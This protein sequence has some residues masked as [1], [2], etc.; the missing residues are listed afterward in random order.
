MSSPSPNSSSNSSPKSSLNSSRVGRLRIAATR[1]V[2]GS[3][4]VLFRIV[5]GL[6]MTWEILRY[7][8][9]GWVAKYYIAP[10]FHFKYWPF[11]FVQAWPGQGMYWH[12]AI[13]G[14]AAL[15]MA[16]GVRYRLAAITFFLGIGWIF[17]LDQTRYL[18]HIYL[19]VLLAFLMIFM[20]VDRLASLD[21]WR[22][23][24]GDGTIPAWSLWLMRFQLGVPYFFGGVA[25][26]NGDWLRG[27]PLT[28][29]LANKTHFPL[30]GP[31]FD[32]PPVAMLMAYSGLL[33][34]LLAP[35]LLLWHRTRLPV[36]IAIVA[37]HLMNSGLFKIGIFPWLMMLGT[38]LFFPAD[39][40]RRMWRDLRQENR[41]AWLGSLFGMGIGIMLGNVVPSTPSGIHSVAAGLMGAFLGYQLATPQ[42]AATPVS[43]PSGG[44]Q[45]GPE[46]RPLA[47]STSLLIAVWV[48]MQ[49]LLP[50]RH[51]AYPGNVHWTEEG[52]LYS[53]HMKLRSKRG[54]LEFVVTNTQTGQTQTLDPK[55]M[56]TK[57]QVSRMAGRP[58]MIVQF[59]HHLA[60][61]L[62]Q[63]HGAPFEVRARGECRLN[64]RA[65]APL[66]DPSVDL[67]QVSR[68][69]LPPADWISRHPPEPRA[70]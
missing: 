61:S 21:P 56:L 47:T 20:P 53:W 30:L 58:D 8:D 14:I 70:N 49:V 12:F 11:D 33:L 31:L 54:S 52:H 15:A 45:P 28:T 27:E 23:K 17:L 3:S 10:G 16:L 6:V 5:F 66:I 64:D 22:G 36:F 18:N 42:L 13:T 19:V 37:F 68:P 46:P 1:R 35:L 59:A 9:H 57:K 2:D 44:S 62:E 24:S 51:F 32:E 65:S 26:L 39:W 40:P 63:E 25:K 69:W 60:R 7:I 67:A 50:L 38:A 34:D 29:W 55:K 41:R 4:L 43:E 48:A